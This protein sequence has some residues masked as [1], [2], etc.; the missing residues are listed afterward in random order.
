MHL[1]LS[2]LLLTACLAVPATH[3][4]TAQTASVDSRLAAQ[5]ALFEEL[6]QADLKNTPE[7][8]TAFGDL[9]SIRS[10][11]SPPVGAPQIWLVWTSVS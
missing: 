3:S 1:Q 7:R 4:L 10:R 9:A 6:Y 5:N 11:A 8:A 2:T